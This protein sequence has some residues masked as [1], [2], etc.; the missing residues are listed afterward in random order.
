MPSIVRNPLIPF[1]SC[2]G[3][4]GIV[5]KPV[6]RTPEAVDASSLAA[7][8]TGQ[9]IPVPGCLRPKNW[10]LLSPFS[11]KE[12]RQRMPSEDSPGRDSPLTT[13]PCRLVDPVQGGDFWPN[14]RGLGYVPWHD[15]SFL[16]YAIDLFREQVAARGLGPCRYRRP[17][18]GE[19]AGRGAQAAIAERESLPTFL[20]GPVHR[21]SCHRRCDC[22]PR[23][24]TIASA[25]PA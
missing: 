4:F 13:M 12:R 19:A 14:L 7:S 23:G 18:P 22:R 3:F 21:T 16:R 8:P 15:V 1:T 2:L 24:G 20:P 10:C 11:F 5:T 25:G 9:G 6:M 17:G